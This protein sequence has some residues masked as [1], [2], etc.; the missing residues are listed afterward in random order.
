MSAPPAR[1]TALTLV[2]G[3]PAAQRE[4]AIAARLAQAGPQAGAADPLRALV[5]V[6]LEGLPSG[7]TLLSPSDSLHVHRIAPGCLCCTGNLVLR[8]TLNRIL[9]LR[10]ELL[11]I[12]LAATDHLDQLRS[13]LQEPP[14][15]QLLELTAD[16]RT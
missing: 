8:V 7:Q 13:W 4:A 15:D 6:V 10:P 1:R 11:F 9:R 5:V 3:G 14:Y 12:G 2:T 16:L